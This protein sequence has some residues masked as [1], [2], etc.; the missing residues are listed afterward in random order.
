MTGKGEAAVVNYRQLAGFEDD[1]GLTTSYDPDNT[2]EKPKTVLNRGLS[3]SAFFIHILALLTTA[4]VVGLNLATVYGWDQGTLRISD[5]QATNLLQF[6]AKLHEIVI[7]GSLTSM[8]MHCIRKR[9]ISRKGLPLGLLSSGYQ[10]TVP[11]Y[12]FSKGFRS[13]CTTDG[14][15]VLT[16]AVAVIY[17]LVVGPSSAVVVIPRLDWWD[18]RAPFEDPQP[19]Y[20]PY[21]LDQLYPTKLGPPNMTLYEGCDTAEYMNHCPGAAFEVLKDW[22]AAWLTNGVQPN[23]SVTEATASAQRA[24]LTGTAPSL[25][26]KRWNFEDSEARMNSEISLVTTMTQPVLQLFDLFWDFLRLTSWSDID[27]FKRPMFISTDTAP[28]YAPVVQAQVRTILL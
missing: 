8:V 23:I 4:A 10:V 9:L 7:V 1:D 2:S 27:T 11:G 5:N 17:V 12:Y 28:I 16:L 3:F 21:S 24:L 25:S 15:L 6:A 14:G 20:L 19:L 18:V 26:W 13:A 22:A